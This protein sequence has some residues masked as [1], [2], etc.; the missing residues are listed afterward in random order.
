MS[1]Y[2]YTINSTG[3][4]SSKYGKCEVCEKRAYHQY[5]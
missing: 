5:D 3:G 1:E 4:S 2:R